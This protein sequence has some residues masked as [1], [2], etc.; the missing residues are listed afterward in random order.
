MG[1]GM[2][3]I[4]NIELNTTNYMS[5]IDSKINS[6]Y[7]LID[8][9][10]KRCS[11]AEDKFESEKLMSSLINLGI[12]LSFAFRILNNV[13]EKIIDTHKNELLETSDIRKVVSE[14]LYESHEILGRKVNSQKCRIWGDL[15]LRKYGN[16]KGPIQIIH[17]DGKIEELSF[18]LLVEE[19]IPDVFSD[20][21][22]IETNKIKNKF[23]KKERTDMGNELMRIILE[24]GIYRLHHR[25]LILLTRDLAM[26]PPHP[27]IV[28]P[29]KTF[30]YIKYNLDKANKNLTDTKTFYEKNNIAR[31]RNS[32]FETIHHT[33][34]AIL[35]QYNEIPGCGLL[36][37]FH[38]LISLLDKL[39]FVFLHP[40]DEVARVE[41]IKNSINVFGESK[42]WTISQDLNIY[43]VSFN[44][45]YS[46]TK[47]LERDLQIHPDKESIQEAIPS[48]EEYMA[49]STNLVHGRE[50]LKEEFNTSLLLITHSFKVR[51]PSFRIPPPFAPGCPAAPSGLCPS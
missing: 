3:Q 24:L 14:S 26:Q 50:R 10:K 15:Y 44:Q 40:S 6:K 22:Q 25:T 32:I 39:S 27:W 8:S 51:I 45:F 36:A 23:S 34:A 28:D 30:E 5:E 43:K 21:L 20:I 49:I 7:T 48:L 11:D 19:I 17:R 13:A 42:I 37:P 18:G 31:C 9:K 12:P 46:L 47:K 29:D 35:G 16:P 41:K 4:L 33:S 38:N 2:E 1:Y